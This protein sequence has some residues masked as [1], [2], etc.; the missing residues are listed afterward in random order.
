M[1]L[2]TAEWYLAINRRCLSRCCRL[3]FNITAICR[4]SVGRFPVRVLD[5]K[6]KKKRVTAR[7]R[8]GGGV[9][10]S[11]LKQHCLGNWTS[12]QRGN[13]SE[14]KSTED[15]LLAV[16]SLICWTKSTKRGLLCNP[17]E[18]L[19][20]DIGRKSWDFG[21]FLDGPEHSSIPI[22][23]LHTGLF[24]LKWTQELYPKRKGKSSAG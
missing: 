7:P 16:E 13:I 23:R 24:V 4:L 8:N 19:R 21:S 6:K 17:L 14:A 9:N 2:F 15:L 18:D 3:F 20:T 1:C 22:E 5:E 10:T 12:L 11:T